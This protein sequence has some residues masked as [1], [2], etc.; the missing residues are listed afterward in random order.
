M[1]KG[2]QAV[3]RVLTVLTENLLRMLRTS[4]GGRCLGSTTKGTTGDTDAAHRVLQGWLTARHRGRSMMV[5]PVWVGLR[6]PRFLS[7]GSLEKLGL[8][9]CSLAAGDRD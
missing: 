7:F 8:N 1:E 6:G 9:E 2:G 4:D 5:R 3:S